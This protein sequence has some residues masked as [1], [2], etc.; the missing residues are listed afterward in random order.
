MNK[1]Y[2]SW[3]LFGLM[4]DRLVT[5]IKK[6]KTKF[7]GVYGIPRGGLILAVCLAHKLNLPFRQKCTKNSLL[8]DD[9]SDTGKTLS[10][11]GGCYKK[12][13]TLYT[14]TWTMI[15]PDFAISLKQDKGDWIIFPWEEYINK[16]EKERQTTLDEFGI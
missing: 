12:I 7:D 13:A 6:S 4:A 3:E 9:I 8:V 16:M 11:E 10:L 2:L 14:T 15:Q 5:N 1:I